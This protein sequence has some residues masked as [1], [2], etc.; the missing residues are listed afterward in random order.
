MQPDD[1]ERDFKRIRRGGESSDHSSTGI[2][3][4]VV[5]GSGERPRKRRA[6]EERSK[7]DFSKIPKEEQGGA[8]RV[9]SDDS[10]NVN[11][12]PIP[13]SV[14]RER[15]IKHGP[16]GGDAVLRPG[17]HPHDDRRG[18]RGSPLR[19]HR[20]GR[21]GRERMMRDRFRDDRMRHDRRDDRERT[22]ARKSRCR[23]YDGMLCLT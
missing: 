16:E 8:R 18:R 14:H 5:P 22:G 1:D 3:S 19:D 2:A 23:D 12:Y 17:M 10:R 15:G 21:M 13:S 4:S 9:D 6:D 7:G 11:V 20:G